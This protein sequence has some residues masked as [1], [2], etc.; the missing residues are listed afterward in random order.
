MVA[1]LLLGLGIGYGVFSSGVGRTERQPIRR[2]F[3]SVVRAQER[4]DDAGLSAPSFRPS[5][6]T[7]EALSTP[8]A[9][10]APRVSEA[11]VQEAMARMA[12]KGRARI[13][14][15]EEI[16][17]SVLTTDGDP[18]P[19]VVIRATRANAVGNVGK[20][21]DYLKGAPPVSLDEAMRQAAEKFQEAS[22]G[23]Y[24][25]SSN[26][27]GSYRFAELPE[28]SYSIAAYLPDYQVVPEVRSSNSIPAGT[29]FNL[30]GTAAGE[31]II[32]VQFEDG[33]VPESA[34]IQC[35]EG[36]S[37]N[38]PRSMW[39]WT[40]GNRQMRF[41]SGR[42]QLTAMTFDA[43]T[44]YPQEDKAIQS[45]DKLSLKLV[46]GATQSAS[47]T[48]KSQSA[49]RG[50]VTFQPDVIQL[51]Y[52]RAHLMAI[53]DTEDVDLEAL[54]QSEPSDWAR[55]LS[56][57]VFNDL[58]PGRY[59]VGIAREWSG[60]IVAHTIVEVEDGIARCRL[61]L[62]KLDASKLIRVHAIG[63]DGEPI[64]QLQ[65]QFIHKRANGGSNS[66]SI[67]PKWSKDGVGFVS[68]PGD[69]IKTYF[70]NK[71]SKAK[72]I[73]KATH[74]DYGSREVVLERGQTEVDFAFEEGAELE[75][76]VAGIVGSSYMGRISVSITQP[77]SERN[78]SDRKNRVGPGG[79]YNSKKLSPGQYLVKL[80]LNP[81]GNAYWSENAIASRTVNVRAGFNATQLTV[82]TL[83]EL[84]VNIA[85]AEEG[86]QSW[87]QREDAEGNPSMAGY[88]A[89]DSDGNLTFDGL[90]PGEYKL[91]AQTSE[92]QQRMTLTVPTG[93]VIFTPD[94][95]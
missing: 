79:I 62:P 46:Q 7:D 5:A 87:L 71:K 31:V 36:S 29:E 65:F 83:Y 1:G 6:A 56:E 63:P 11:R 60:P 80:I 72:F 8:E 33:S 25:T 55:H 48:L 77:G 35:N 34:I 23:R 78:W 19:G 32:D 73:L 58:T 85:D 91:T 15:E 75:V 27:E 30:I 12:I 18:L 50:I 13:K 37:D 3:G 24:Q 90:S 9:S 89:V 86:S 42:I 57:F 95:E 26:I 68:I 16:W 22:S 28:G 47:L 54:G 41:P 52:C 4:P 61:T 67:N 20:Q 45:S 44:A 21:D 40:P 43:G 76:T 74:E 82:P 53:G 59:A 17:G 51:D 92:G 14:G 88:Q 2:G 66:N 10:S 38:S 69:A 49:I 70:N 64:S 84:E 81:K 39:K 93:R 94:E